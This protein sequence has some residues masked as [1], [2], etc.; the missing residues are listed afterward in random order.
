[1]ARTQDRGLRILG[2]EPSM[3]A[4]HNGMRPESWHGPSSPARQQLAGGA[5]GLEWVGQGFRE[6]GEQ[7]S[8]TGTSSSVQPGPGR[9]GR[10]RL[11]ATVV[12][13]AKATLRVPHRRTQTLLDFPPCPLV[14]ATECAEC[15]SAT[16]LRHGLPCLAGH[17]RNPH[18]KATVAYSLLPLKTRYA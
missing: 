6:T 4:T 13:R 15:G 7:R 18:A 3:R 11:P 1:M 12:S 10:L 17:L 16:G 2:G 8:G 14:R 9:H 5:K